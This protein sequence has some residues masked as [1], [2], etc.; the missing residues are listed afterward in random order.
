[1]SDLS[2]RIREHID[3]A[4]PPLDVDALVAGLVADTVPTISKGPDAKPKPDRRLRPVLASVFAVVLVLGFGAVTWLLRPTEPERQPAVLGPALILEPSQEIGGGTGSLRI[5]IRDWSGVE[6]YQLLAGVWAQDS[7]SGDGPL[8]GGAFWTLI[9]SD[10]FSAEDV[11]H[12]PVDPYENPRELD[13]FSWG[14]EDYLWEERAWLDSGNYRIV[15]WANPDVLHPYGSHFPGSPIERTCEVDVEVIGG[16]VTTVVI[17]GVPVGGGPCPTPSQALNTHTVVVT[18]NG[19]QGH[20][21]WDM[22]G[23]L[24]RSAEPSWIDAVGGFAAHVASNN[25]STTQPIRQGADEDSDTYGDSPFP[26]VTEE[27]QLVE[28][29]TYTLAL[30]A[31]NNLGPYSRWMPGL[32]AGVELIGCQVVFE[33][34]QRQ[35]ETTVTVSGDSLVPDGTNPSKC[36]TSP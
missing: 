32:S 18:V 21:G 9:A 12:P 27:T 1:M 29:G 8:V 17:S 11:V 23:V 25:F 22:A 19:F 13:Y 3:S 16:E 5:S 14:A 36:T 4:A 35:Q 30:W 7:D 20:A 24:Y 26:Y 34:E 33:V 28:P 10:P 15:F 6:G 2:T 31:S